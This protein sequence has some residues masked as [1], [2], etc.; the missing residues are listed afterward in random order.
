MRYQTAFVTAVTA[1]LATAFPRMA[2]FASDKRALLSTRAD[3]PASGVPIPDPAQV[4]GTFDAELQYVSNTGDHAYVAPGA[5]DQRGP[6]PGE[7][8]PCIMARYNNTAQSGLNAMANHVLH[9]E[10][11]T[12]LSKLI[13]K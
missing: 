6:C 10:C 4:A 13:S 5:G 8:S 3:G 9:T 12:Y 7:C 2:T 1:Q 11:R